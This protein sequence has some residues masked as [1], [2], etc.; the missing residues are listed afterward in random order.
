MSLICITICLSVSS[1][2]FWPTKPLFIPYHVS[3]MLPIHSPTSFCQSLPQTGPSLISPSSIKHF[4]LRVQAIIFSK[5]SCGTIPCSQPLDLFSYPPKDLR[6]CPHHHCLILHQYM[7]RAL[8]H[9]LNILEESLLQLQGKQE[10]SEGKNLHTCPYPMRIPVSSNQKAANLLKDQMPPYLQSFSLTYS[11]SKVA[12]TCMHTRFLSNSSL[13][14]DLLPC[15]SS[16]NS[17]PHFVRG[18][19][20]FLHLILAFPG[21]KEIEYPNT[22]TYFYFLPPKITSGEEKLGLSLEDWQEDCSQAS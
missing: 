7:R 11:Q 21:I 20:I 10:I 17:S 2:P 15:F 1:F 6:V 12:H 16:G 4:C 14:P 8:T 22:Q 19:P 3:T 13:S 5:F 9:Q 18:L